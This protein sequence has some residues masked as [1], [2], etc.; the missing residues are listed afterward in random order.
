MRN[1]LLRPLKEQMALGTCSGHQQGGVQAKSQH[2]PS[3]WVGVPLATRW[4]LP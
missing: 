2:V 1:K 4:I 3:P